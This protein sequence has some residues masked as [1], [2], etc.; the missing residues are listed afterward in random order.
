[1]TTKPRYHH[2][3]LRKA[4]IDA[5]AE[6]AAE[7]GSESVSLREVAKR[8]RVSHAAPYHHFSGKAEL[9]HAVALEGFRLMREEM[10]VAVA[11][12]T[13]GTPYDRLGALGA[14]YIRF[15]A[16]YPYYF[17][18][19][20]RGVKADKAFPDPD[21]Y[22]QKNF[23]ALVAS[24]QACRGETG[25]PTK[26]TMNLVLTAWSIVHGMASLWVENSFC[27]T[28]FESVSIDRLSRA[29]IESSRNIFEADQLSIR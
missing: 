21:D 18:A 2:G 24:V 1:M 17:K 12:K 7:R 10:Q 15:A 8:A 22:G 3:D 27:D 14:A 28:P 20:F 5:A 6:L 11:R 25:K 9:L 23:N 13:R 4:L 19:M 26:Q 29:V 16:R